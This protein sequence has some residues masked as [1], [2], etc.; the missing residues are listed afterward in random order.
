MPVVDVQAIVGIEVTHD[1]HVGLAHTV[2]SSVIFPHRDATD[3]LHRCIVF[4]PALYRG[5]RRKHVVSRNGFARSFDEI[6]T[7]KKDS[8]ELLRVFKKEATQNRNHGY[9]VS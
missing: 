7:S 5:K 3:V 6:N 8:G 2:F 4:V 9:I 1:R